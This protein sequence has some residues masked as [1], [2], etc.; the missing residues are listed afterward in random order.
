MGLND[1]KTS[2]ISVGEKLT[3][4]I[5]KPDA[6]H[7]ISITNSKIKYFMLFILSIAFSL[8]ISHAKFPIKFTSAS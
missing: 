6:K 2:G 8:K 1:E 7:S 5:K 4:I 3:I